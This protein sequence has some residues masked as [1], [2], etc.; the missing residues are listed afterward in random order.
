VNQTVK[1]IIF[2]GR[3]QGIGFRFTAL[4]IAN[5]YR[6]TGVVRNLPDGT[7][8]MIAQGPAGDIAD[9]IRDIKE[10]FGV[11]IRETKIEEIRTDS[12]Y[13]DFKITF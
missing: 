7:V 8:E 2:T 3:V 11:Y 9:C 4:D 13:K 12:Q 10:S 5:H 1:H 6:L